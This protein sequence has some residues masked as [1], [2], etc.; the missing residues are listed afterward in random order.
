[1]EHL[2]TSIIA[3]AAQTML[4]S[5]T[6]PFSSFSFF[7]L[8][9]MWEPGIRQGQPTS[10]KLN[11]TSLYIFSQGGQMSSFLAHKAAFTLKNT[12]TTELQELID[13][14]QGSFSYIDQSRLLNLI[15]YY[16]KFCT[17]TCT[18]FIVQDKSEICQFRTLS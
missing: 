16:K 7:K 12:V 5:E 4:Q 8:H 6:A 10:C 2:Q 18:L 15:L 1:M 14:F 3:H 11:Y 17:A 13:V 9:S